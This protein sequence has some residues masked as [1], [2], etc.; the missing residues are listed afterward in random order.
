MPVQKEKIRRKKRKKGT[1]QKR[2]NMVGKRDRVG[3]NWNSKWRIEKTD[4]NKSC[5]ENYPR[6]I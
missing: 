6:E 3:V 5:D 4:R 1:K 2:E